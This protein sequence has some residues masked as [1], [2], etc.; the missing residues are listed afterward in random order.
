MRLRR[1]LSRNKDSKN[2]QEN[3][4]LT[5]NTIRSIGLKSLVKIKEKYD[6]KKNPI[7]QKTTQKTTQSGKTINMSNMLNLG[8][9][10]RIYEQ[11]LIL[12]ELKQ[13]TSLV[14]RINKRIE[15]IEYKV[16]N[17]KKTER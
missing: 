6:S 14:K 15:R 9:K 10:A 3:L 12:K 2:T 11:K 17:N 1:Y 8:T 7:S 5:N 13:L 16:I 4:L